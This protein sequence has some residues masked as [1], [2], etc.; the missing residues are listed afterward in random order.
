MR[1]GIGELR[2]HQ[3]AGSFYFDEGVINTYGKHDV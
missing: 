2:Y 1:K 3:P